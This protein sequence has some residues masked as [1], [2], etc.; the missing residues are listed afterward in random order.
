MTLTK[1]LIFLHGWD[2]NLQPAKFDQ[3]PSC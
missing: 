3:E 2:W 1:K